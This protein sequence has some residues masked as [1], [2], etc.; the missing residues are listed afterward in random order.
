MQQK[1]CKI[2]LKKNPRKQSK[3]KAMETEEKR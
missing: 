2:K 3:D 1:L